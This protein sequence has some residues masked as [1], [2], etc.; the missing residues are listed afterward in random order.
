MLRYSA[1]DS[2][3]RSRK[4]PALPGLPGFQTSNTHASGNVPPE[5]ANRGVRTVRLSTDTDTSIGP[6]YGYGYFSRS[7]LRILD[8]VCGYRTITRRTHGHETKLQSHMC[9]R[10]ACTCAWHVREHARA[11]APFSQTSL[12]Y[13][14]VVRTATATSGRVG[15]IIIVRQTDHVRRTRAF[16]LRRVRECCVRS[17]CRSWEG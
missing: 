10:A 11:R 4:L 15:L 17:S 7:C 9:M 5:R 16:L 3:H 12:T 1:N 8:T 6:V 13:Y 14:G 2:T